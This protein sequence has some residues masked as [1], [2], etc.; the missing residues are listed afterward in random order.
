MRQVPESCAVQVGRFVVS[1][2]EEAVKLTIRLQLDGLVNIA[3][4][5]DNL[6]DVFFANYVVR[7]VLVHHG[8]TPTS[9]HYKAVLLTATGALKDAFYTDDATAARKVKSSEHQSIEHN[10]YVFLLQR[11]N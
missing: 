7:A 1:P 11:T 5:R 2:S 4:F 6:C 8:E 10:A 3:V 9:G